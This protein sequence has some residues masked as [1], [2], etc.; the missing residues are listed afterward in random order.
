[1]PFMPSEARP[2]VRLLV[3]DCG[4]YHRSALPTGRICFGLGIEEARLA[5]QAASLGGPATS[6]CF[7]F[8]YPR[9]LEQRQNRFRES[10]PLNLRSTKGSTSV[11]RE[12]ESV[13]SIPGIFL[14]HGGIG[15]PGF[16]R[17]GCL[18]S[19]PIQSAPDGVS[20][21]IH[22]GFSGHCNAAS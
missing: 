15:F 22:R 1:M 20:R 16:D 8:H 11:S 6:D 17:R 9:M 21:A 7:A 4:E 10:A 19:L 5:N 13:V 18:D 14:C 2:G 12:L 3:N